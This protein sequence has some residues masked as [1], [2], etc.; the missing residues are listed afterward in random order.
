M[1][2]LP[3]TLDRDESGAYRV[4]IGGDLLTVPDLVLRARPGLAARAGRP[5]IVGIRPEDAEDA[6]IAGQAGGRTLSASADVVEPLGSDVI[7]YLSLCD[8]AGTAPP[9]PPG[10]RPGP[11]LATTGASTLVARFSPQSA[12]KVGDRVLARVNVDRM[13]F[14]EPESGAAIWDT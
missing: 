5:V 14:F 7:V 8:P 11:A 12:V 4:R 9:D 2:L 13:H 10:P 6:V 3:G 1:N